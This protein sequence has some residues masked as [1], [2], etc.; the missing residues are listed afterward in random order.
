[1]SNDEV[2]GVGENTYSISGNELL[3][4]DTKYDGHPISNVFANN[5][6]DDYKN[7]VSVQNI[8][9]V[10]V[11]YFNPN[12]EIAK[13]FSS[14]DIL[15][16]GDIVSLSSDDTTF[17]CVTGR[18]FRKL[19]VPIIDAELQ[20]LV[21]DIPPGLFNKQNNEFVSWDELV[22]GGYIKLSEDGKTVTS[23][24]S[25]RLR[26]CLKISSD[27]SALSASVF[28]QCQLEWIS[29]PDSVKTVGR[30]CFNARALKTLIISAESIGNYANT[31]SLFGD[32]VLKELDIKE[33]VISIGEGSFGNC[34]LVKDLRFPKT[35][36]TIGIWSF[37]GIG[38]YDL[39]IPENVTSIGN[40]AFSDCLNLTSLKINSKNI[41][42][43]YYAFDGCEKLKE[44]TINSEVPPILNTRIDNIFPNSVSIINIP[45]GTLDTY[46]NATNWSLW[47]DKFVE[48]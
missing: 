13:D 7:G 18:N 37:M 25:S 5:I 27:I 9:I 30:S 22:N 1:M 12:G 36:Q 33:G 40:G 8:S 11:D 28:S 39:T 4:K 35:L 44:I 29:V 34:S 47:A 42:L 24:D 2:F 38:I 48:G 45:N 17:W 46:K 16:P 26:G 43:D 32:P 41:T 15:N 20:A 23:C 3:Q 10:C 19:G 31:S 21:F 6:L 14:G